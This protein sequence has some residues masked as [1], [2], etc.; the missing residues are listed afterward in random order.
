MGAGNR[1]RKGEGSGVS[2]ALENENIATVKPLRRGRSSYGE[3]EIRTVGEGNGE[4]EGQIEGNTSREK[5]QSTTAIVKGGTKDTEKPL[6]RGRSS[7][8]EV[9]LRVLGE[10]SGGVGTHGIEGLK[11]KK[12]GRSAA[13]KA[14][15]DPVG[16]NEGQSIPKKRGR[17]SAVRAEEQV[18]ELLG[19]QSEQAT[20]S[21]KRG[22]LFGD[23][24][25]AVE[26]AP[27]AEIA[28]KRR[29]RRS[30]GRVEDQVDEL[31]AEVPEEAAPARRSRSSLGQIERPKAPTEDHGDELVAEEPRQGATLKKISRGPAAA[32]EKAAE[33][34]LRK[35][36]KKR[37]RP[38]LSQF[39]QVTISTSAP[40]DQGQ[41]TKRRGRPAA[42][43]NV[44]GHVSEDSTPWDTRMRRPVG[45]DME[46]EAG[47]VGNEDTPARGRARRRRSDVVEEEDSQPKGQQIGRKRAHQSDIQVDIQADEEPTVRGRRTRRSNTESQQVVPEQVVATISKPTKSSRRSE[48]VEVETASSKLTKN[49]GDKRLKATSSN[50]APTA[51][52]GSSSTKIAIKAKKATRLSNV[53]PS[54][55]SQTHKKGSK[56]TSQ[57]EPPRQKRKGA[58]NTEPMSSKRQRIEKASAQNHHYEPELD[59]LNYQHLEAVTRRVSR[60][61]IEAK[62]EALPPIAIDRISQLLGDLQKP[63][64]A[65]LN[66]ERKKT[67]ASTALGGISRKLITKI[68]RGI[69][70]P[71]GTRNH[72]E[73]DFDFEKI[74][75]HNRALEAQLT[76]ALH[77]NELLEAELN[78]EMARL[79][80]DMETLA[81]LEK[82]AKT[83]ASVR[84]QAG[85]KL[86]SVLQPDSSTR[87]IEVLNDDIG[88]SVDQQ[89]QYLDLGVQDD[90]NLQALVQEL[91][92]HVD[93]IQGNIKQV[94]GISQAM[95]NSK[96][97]VQATLFD[98]LDNSQ[99]SDV[100]LGAEQGL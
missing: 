67:Q 74:L 19:E 55:P 21:R 56:Q 87:D 34:H 89:F 80:S 36:S 17:P 26:Q 94:R 14:R 20:V 93:T 51:K 57:E 46:R 13:A 18:D 99:Y 9:E 43:E 25:K 5:K 59:M 10:T 15:V 60:E 50:P 68:S 12:W 88:L 30:I 54:A 83:E 70:F 61:T 49:R 66:D 7:A 44:V 47:R 2:V 52:K 96:A 31:L 81:K 97:A 91:D 85:R 1:G 42:V 41:V 23:I 71:P 11:G 73:D 86:H 90:E 45:K 6:R 82:N 62:W 32:N 79:E 22:R 92:G 16:E 72:R 84:N 38:S 29:S 37:G 98:H 8:G 4:G 78:K 64:V 53:T 40:E 3:A 48:V 24:E 100:V 65:R 76:P 33:D 39:K 58:E 27:K 35:A 63:V 95:A 69:P 28:S 75:D 77:S